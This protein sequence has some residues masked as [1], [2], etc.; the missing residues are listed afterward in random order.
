MNKLRRSARMILFDTLGVLLIIASPFTGVL[1]GPGGIPVFLIGL[2][3]IAVHHEWAQR[4][5]DMVKSYADRL[6]DV[7]FQP[8]FYLLFDILSPPMVVAGIFVLT[9]PD[10]P[11]WMMPIGVA[12]ISLALIVFFGNRQ[13]WQRLKRAVKAKRKAS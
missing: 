6:G 5:I 9:R 3:L 12:T 8:R 1:P 10:A 2:S 4:Y 11:G 13:R 7:I